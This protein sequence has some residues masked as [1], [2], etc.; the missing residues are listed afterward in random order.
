MDREISEKLTEEAASGDGVAA[1]G[2]RSPRLRFS[3]HVPRVVDHLA[4]AFVL[5]FLV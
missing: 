2:A 1:L 3:F 4:L 5:Y